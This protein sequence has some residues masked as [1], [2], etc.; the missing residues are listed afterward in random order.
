[1]EV[2]FLSQ[3]PCIY[4]KKPTSMHLLCLVFSHY[5]DS[6]FEH[7]DMPYAGSVYTLINTH[8][9]RLSLSINGQTASM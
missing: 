7:K 3:L 4:S 1:M 6:I 8:Q 5:K 9:K 2:G